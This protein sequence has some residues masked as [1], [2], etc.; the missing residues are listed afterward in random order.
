[1]LDL[2]IDRSIEGTEAAQAAAASLLAARDPGVCVCEVLTK[3][4]LPL[5]RSP[6][7]SSRLSARVVRRSHA[8]RADDRECELVGRALELEPR[9]PSPRD[10]EGRAHERIRRG[11]QATATGART[12]DDE[13]R[14]QALSFYSR[15]LS[16]GAL[17]AHTT[18]DGRVAREQPLAEQR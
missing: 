17:A 16:A 6:I 4:S 13:R 1:M 5:S 9:R 3:T 7:V 14:A 2:S 11:R 10:G 12:P 8:I 18:L 15:L